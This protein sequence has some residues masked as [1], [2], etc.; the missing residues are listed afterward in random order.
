MK[1][2]RSPLALFVLAMTAY[3]IL[4]ATAVIL[5][6]RFPETPWRIPIALAPAIPGI[7]V[8]V[9]VAREIGRRDELQRQIQLEALAFAFAATAIVA[10]SLGLLANAGIQQINSTFYVPIMVGLWGVGQ[11]L[12]ARRYR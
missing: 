11:I 9:A 12:A 8:A 2:A 3:V 4:V 10:L 7:I 5:L 6:S 1:N